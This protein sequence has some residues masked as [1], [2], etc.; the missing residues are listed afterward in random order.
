MYVTVR[1]KR[2]GERGGGGGGG[3]GPGNEEE[4]WREMER[5]YRATEMLASIPCLSAR[6][7]LKHHSP[8]GTCNTEH[9]FSKSTS[10]S[11]PLT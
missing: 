5:Y 4:V 2:G 7:C 10:L 8:S 6:Q 1:G 3:V 9:I 11:T